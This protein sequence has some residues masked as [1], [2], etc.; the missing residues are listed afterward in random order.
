MVGIV[1]S[2]F[3]ATIPILAYLFF[4][5]W[6][7]RYDREPIWLLL[8]TFFWGGFGGVILA[9]IGSIALGLSMTVIFGITGSDPLDTVVIAPVVEELTKGVFLLA[10]FARRDFDN[11]TDG[12]VYGAAAGLGFAMTENFLYFINAYWEGGAGSWIQ[13]VF[14]RTLYSGVMHCF[15]TAILGASLGYTK[16]ASGTVRK[17]FM[18]MF[19]LAAA[20]GIH[21]FWNGSLVLVGQTGSMLPLV[22]ALIGIPFFGLCL[23][24]LTQLSLMLESRT[25]AAELREEVSLGIIPEAHL[26]ILPNY[27][28]R[29][30]GGWLPSTVIKRRYVPLATTLA[31]RKF[32][33]KRC[34]PS[35]IA[36]FDAEITRLRNEVRRVLNR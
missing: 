5:W 27:F 13:V 12:I 33:R 1:L 9:I 16:Y 8:L 17:F 23:M 15:S 11:T 21:A 34:A 25:I 4:V 36:S 22:V 18:P 14:M 29:A 2:V 19:G 24:T 26:A 31:F 28:R 6:L 3:F 10:I 20:M 32:Q 30:S 7:D 35:E